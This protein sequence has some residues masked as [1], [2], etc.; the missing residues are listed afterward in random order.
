M[1]PGGKLRRRKRIAPGVLLKCTRV[2]AGDGLR[3][4]W[5]EPAALSAA[6]T[7]KTTT[8]RFRHFSSCATT[9]SEVIFHGK[10]DVAS[11]LRAV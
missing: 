5:T 4:G 3:A 2:H 8:D 1:L 11:T 9:C 6:A 10:L 7:S